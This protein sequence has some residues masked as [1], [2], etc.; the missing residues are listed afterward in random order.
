[1]IQ[2]PDVAP[3]NVIFGDVSP[4]GEVTNCR[5]IKHASIAACP[6]AIMVAS[7][8]RESDESCR[9]D[10]PDHG[11]MAEWGYRWNGYLW[12]ADE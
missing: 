7:H 4:D 2:M 9:C 11:E 3:E 6:F 8:Y 5:T 10:D 1:M 12:V